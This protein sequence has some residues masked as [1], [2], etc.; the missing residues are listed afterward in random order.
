MSAWAA[1]ILNLHFK[2]IAIRVYE[3]FRG[4]EGNRRQPD[5]RKATLAVAR[6]PTLIY[7]AHVL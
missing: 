5:H 6:E 7:F 3:L 2:S 4:A 1:I